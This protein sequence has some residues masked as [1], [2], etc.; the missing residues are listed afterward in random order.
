MRSYLVELR[1]SKDETQDD[2]AEA[3]GVTRS[4]YS[5]IES[6]LR[7][8]KMDI[9]L[10]VALAKHFGLTPIEIIEMEQ[11][12]EARNEQQAPRSSRQGDG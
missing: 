3:I 9:T 6:G 10:I 12:E 7:Q 1:Q 4:Y 5:M 2:V 11:R 8:K